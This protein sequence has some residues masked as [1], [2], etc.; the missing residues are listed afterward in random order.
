MYF[1]RTI[2]TRQLAEK[3]KSNHKN[4][5]NWLVTK[6]KY[7]SWSE[8]YDHDSALLIRW[9]HDISFEGSGGYACLSANPTLQRKGSIRPRKPACATC[10]RI[11]LN[12]VKHARCSILDCLPD[13]CCQ[14]AVAINPGKGNRPAL[15]QIRQVN[16]SLVI[17]GDLTQ[18][19]RLP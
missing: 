2:K 18:Q 1:F 14:K 11:I 3:A 4:V 7:E 15:R 13:A 12:H 17:H 8:A 9:Q 5:T 10:N 16:F 6:A 19:G